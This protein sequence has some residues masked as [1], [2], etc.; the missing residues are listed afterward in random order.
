[1]IIS[2]IRGHVSGFWFH[3]AA[4]A[5][6]V[7]VNAIG[8]VFADG[9]NFVQSWGGGIAAVIATFFLVFK[10]QGYWAWMMVNA[11]LWCAL[12]FNMGL[13]LLGWLQVSF[14]IFSAYGAVQWALVKYRVGFNPRVRIDIIGSIIALGVFL[15]TVYAY[16]P[17]NGVGIWWALEAG[18]VVL[19][20][21]AMWMDA[22]RYRANWIAW[23]ISNCFAWPLF[24]HGKLWGPFFTTFVYQAINIV[25]WFVWT[26][27]NRVDHPVVEEMD[28]HI[29]N[30][31]VDSSDRFVWKADDG[32]LLRSVDDA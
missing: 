17:I 2:T 24:Y 6:F 10:S 28:W 23:S 8:Y 18:S 11:A 14:L 31:S 1:M 29:E 30:A 20:I 32:P 25:G 19:A 27:D 7:V 22:F 21:A 9:I 16:W 4:A 15:V 5:L 3:F 26:K 13:P 12:F